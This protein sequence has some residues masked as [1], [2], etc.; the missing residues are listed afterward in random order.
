MVPV[1]VKEERQIAL[2]FDPP[3]DRWSGIARRVDLTDQ[4]R[5]FRRELGLPEGTPLVFSG[6]QA[7]I[8]HP[9]ILAKYFAAGALAEAIG[10]TAAWIT[11][12]HVPLDAHEIEYPT[13]DGSRARL[14]ITATSGKQKIACAAGPAH[15]ESVDLAEMGMTDSVSDG[16]VRILRALRV[17]EAEPT[18]E[19]QFVRALDALVGAY[20]KPLKTISTTSLSE[21]ALFA[22]L[23][24]K[25][26][27]DAGGMAHAY[28]RAVDSVPDA[29]VAKLLV[30]ADAEGIELPLWVLGDDGAA[31]TA[32]LRDLHGVDA[33][34][35]APKALLM[36]GMMRLAGC[37]LFIHG[38][39]GMRYDRVTEVWFREWLGVELAPIAMASA[40]VRLP[41][42]MGPVDERDVARAKWRHHH[43][44][45]NPNIVGDSSFEQ[46]KRTLLARIESGERSSTERVDLYAKLHALLGAYRSAN[47]AA[48]RSLDAEVSKIEQGLAKTRLARSRDW[49]FPLYGREMIRSLREQIYGA[50]LA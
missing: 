34:K 7:V 16:A 10:G 39:G 13:A 43:A 6:H 42:G 18:L 11:V 3:A 22:G 29:G 46:A 50:F 20:T 2:R 17:G 4:Q 21:T 36:T 23:V 33:S 14:P 28:N 41:I 38:L 37:E 24:D 44:M 19:R 49:A 15:V 35:L 8:W 9:G 1:Q 40:D 26:C 5:V 31:R 48:L 47:R 12:G 32:I 30:G 27:A 25:M 45:H